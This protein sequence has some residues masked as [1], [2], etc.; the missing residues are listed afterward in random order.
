MRLGGGIAPVFTAAG[1]AGFSG[2]PLPA[3]SH[4]PIPDSSMVLF[5]SSRGSLLNIS[6]FF[7]SQATPLMVS[8][9]HEDLVRDIVDYSE[10][11]VY[12]TLKS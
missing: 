7:P 10:V 2:S 12:K 1:L 6:S 3:L 8:V 11:G 9:H 4:P 5:G